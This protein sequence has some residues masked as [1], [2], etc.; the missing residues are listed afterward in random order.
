[1][2]VEGVG[3]LDRVSLSSHLILEGRGSQG[4]Q[5]GPSPGGH[6]KEEDAMCTNWPPCVHVQVPGR[7]AIP[8]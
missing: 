8:S 6:G 5:Y 7:Q 3:R 1:M 2:R 4:L